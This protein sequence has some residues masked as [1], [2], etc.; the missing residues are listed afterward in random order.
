MGSLGRGLVVGWFVPS[1]FLRVRRYK[2]DRTS[3]GDKKVESV[4]EE[5]RERE[6]KRESGPLNCLPIKT[7]S[8]LYLFFSSSC[9]LLYSSNLLHLYTHCNDPSSSYKAPKASS[10]E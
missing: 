2:N 7:Y 3:K 6:R 9:F 1:P 8:F 4:Y 5:R 10:G